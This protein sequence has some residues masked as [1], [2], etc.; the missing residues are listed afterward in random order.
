MATLAA[1]FDAPSTFPPATKPGSTS[2]PIGVGPDCL[3]SVLHGVLDARKA[4]GKRHELAAVLAVVVAATASGA[5]GYTAITQWAAHQS[6][7]SRTAAPAK[8]RGQTAGQLTRKRDVHT[9]NGQD[10]N[11]RVR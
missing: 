9:S 11:R 8:P 7:G 1:A 4:R 3:L 6:L 10:F 5:N 2:T